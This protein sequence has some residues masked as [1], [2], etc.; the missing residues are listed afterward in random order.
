MK[1]RETEEKKVSK[2][3][4]FVYA[5]V[6]DKPTIREDRDYVIAGYYNED[7]TKFKN[8]ATGEIYDCDKY[9]LDLDNLNIAGREFSTIVSAGMSMPNMFDIYFS[10]RLKTKS[11]GKLDWFRFEYVV[12]HPLFGDK[13]WVAKN[14]TMKSIHEFFI[15]LREEEEVKLS[16]VRKI[17]NIFNKLSHNSL[18]IFY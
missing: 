6:M 5:E 2:K 11:I 17:V 8:I 15:N 7:K 16:D 14:L 3:D 12:Q 1:K 18:T 10:Q 9:N 4:I 13:L